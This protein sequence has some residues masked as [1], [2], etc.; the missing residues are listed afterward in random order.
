MRGFTLPLGRGLKRRDRADRLD[1]VAP[2]TAHWVHLD[3]LPPRR[4]PAWRG[5]AWSRVRN[6]G[7]SCR[8]PSQA[9]L[10]P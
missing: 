3:G 6:C 7:C 8:T 5:P 4:W 10:G 2:D 1:L 9:A